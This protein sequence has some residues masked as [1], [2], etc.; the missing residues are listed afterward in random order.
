VGVVLVVTMLLEVVLL[1]QIRLP[2]DMNLLNQQCRDIDSHARQVP[3]KSAFA[4]CC[5]LYQATHMELITLPQPHKHNRAIN[6]I[7]ARYERHYHFGRPAVQSLVLRG[8]RA[9]QVCTR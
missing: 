4:N 6:T 2:L 9:C 5:C 8:T 3:Q 7:L 1:S